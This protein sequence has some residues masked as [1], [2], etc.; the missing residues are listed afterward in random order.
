MKTGKH[1]YSDAGNVEVAISQTNNVL[2]IIRGEGETTLALSPA[3]A[4]QLGAALLRTA[5]M[6]DPAPRP[7]LAPVAASGLPSAS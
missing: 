2:L 6:A 4:R 5:N 1:R 3:Q 7:L